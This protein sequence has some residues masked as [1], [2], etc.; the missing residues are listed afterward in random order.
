VARLVKLGLLE[1]VKVLGSTRYRVSELQAIA[2]RGTD[3]LL[4]EAA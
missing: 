2:E 3:V 4:R 1:P